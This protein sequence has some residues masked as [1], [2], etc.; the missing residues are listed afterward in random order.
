MIRKATAKRSEANA[1]V[2][3]R[4]AGLDQRFKMSASVAGFPS[5]NAATASLSFFCSLA[6]ARTAGEH[7]VL[8]LLRIN[9]P[10]RPSQR[11]ELEDLC[12]AE[13]LQRRSRC[14]GCLQSFEPLQQLCELAAC[15]T[16]AQLNSSWCS[17]EA[18]QY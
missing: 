12:G 10:Q 7:S 16:L 11:F 15:N 9:R 3:S 13:L 14:L 8:Q 5:I 2:L 1:A 17:H 18:L 4:S 6:S